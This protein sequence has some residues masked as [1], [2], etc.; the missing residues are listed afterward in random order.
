MIKKFFVTIALVLLIAGTAYADAD[1]VAGLASPASPGA[2][3]GCQTN[4]EIVKDGVKFVTAQCAIGECFSVEV[5]KRAIYSE[6]WQGGMCTIGDGTNAGDSCFDMRVAVNPTG[7]DFG[8]NFT[9]AVAANLDPITQAADTG[10]DCDLASANSATLRDMAT[11]ATCTD[12]G[13]DNFMSQVVFCRRSA[14]TCGGS[15]GAVDAVDVS[16]WTVKTVTNP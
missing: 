7:A 1:R 15:A 9:N 3:T 8:T 13:C 14:A 12:T 10:V 5:L 11:D 2:D 16:V 6:A 4:V